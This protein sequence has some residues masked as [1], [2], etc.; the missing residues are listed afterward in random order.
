MRRLA[1]PV[2]LA[3]AAL[4]GCGSSGSATD[5]ASTS[6]PGTPKVTLALR[7]S[8]GD[9]QLLACS[10]VH[11]YKV[12]HRGPIDFAGTIAP[13]PAKHFK[14]KVKIK[15]CVDG[16]FQDSGDTRVSGHAGG[17][18]RGSLQAP[19]KGV[20]FARAYYRT[21]HGDVLSAKV[22]FEVK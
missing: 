8:K 10:L 2:L 15:R 16:Q 20:F 21:A 19:G 18:Y 13:V 17:S 1:L 22:Y 6:P 14:L 11:H 7:H 9:E 3:G 4:A 12:Y 5:A